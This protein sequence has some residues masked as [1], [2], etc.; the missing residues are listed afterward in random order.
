MLARII[1]GDTRFPRRASCYRV[2][3]CISVNS[4]DAQVRARARTARRPLAISNK[5]GEEYTYT[6]RSI[7]KRGNVI[8]R[9]THKAVSRTNAHVCVQTR[10]AAHARVYMGERSRDFSSSAAPSYSFFLCPHRSGF[11]GVFFYASYH[12]IGRAQ[13]QEELSAG[14]GETRRVYTCVYTYVPWYSD[15][16]GV[17][18]LR[19]DGLLELL[20]A[21]GLLELLHQTLNGLLAPFVLAL[22]L[23][24]AQQPLDDRRVKAGQHRSH[25]L[26]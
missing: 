8:C 25:H 21:R 5:N 3:A 20:E 12:G 2:D 13:V 14:L 22:G 23:L 24:P 15:A 19:R 6:R 4:R 26:P 1:E 17:A 16:L 10:R 11:G 7:G 9:H 18:A